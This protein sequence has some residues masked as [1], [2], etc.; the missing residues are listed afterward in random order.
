MAA[1]LIGIAAI[2][3][4]FTS[5]KYYQIYKN[6]D[7]YSEVFKIAVNYY[8]HE[9]EPEDLANNSI[10]GM[11]KSL[12]PYSVYYD[13]SDNETLELMNNNRY[14]GFGV[15]INR[16]DSVNTLVSVNEEFPAYKSGLRIGDI[17]LTIDGVQVANLSSEELRNY[18]KGEANSISQIEVLRNKDTLKFTIQREIINLKDVTFYNVFDDG[19]AYIYLEGFSRNA[20]IEVKNA[21]HDMSINHDLKGLVLDLRGNPG[22]LL[23]SAIAICEYFVP[24]G[25]LIVYTKGRDEDKVKSYYSTSDPLFPKL[26]VAVLI[27]EGSASASEIVAGAFQDLD[28]GIV[29]G[30]NSFGKGLVQS[31]FDLP[32]N[33]NMKITTAK[34]Y[35]PS[36]RCIQKINYGKDASFA[37]T[38]KFFT[39]NG[40]EVIEAHGITPDSIFQKNDIPNYINDLRDNYLI[41]KFGN[42]IAYQNSEFQLKDTIKNNLINNFKDFLLSSKY[43]FSKG[44]LQQIDNLKNTADEYEVSEKLIKQIE[45]LKLTVIEDKINL[46][47]EDSEMLKIV[48]QSE[49]LSRYVSNQELSKF[50][51]SNNR[52]IRKTIEL[53]KDRTK[54]DLILSNNKSNIQNKN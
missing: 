1:V 48:L 46:S 35:T 29:V 54:Y 34:Y 21:L 4:G 52:T 51:V 6:F 40:R 8:V 27:D 5:D 24:R 17:L 36:G 18:T 50:L 31:V 41:F 25:S 26:P 30:R 39:S 42:Y 47:N 13:E 22:G 19:I 20:P 11:L 14:V 37:D 44:I 33:A 43:E 23:Y 10:V 16:I 7:I 9:L 38:L 12:D 32:Y 49:I 53:L 28:R 2:F 45:E 3:S 15:S